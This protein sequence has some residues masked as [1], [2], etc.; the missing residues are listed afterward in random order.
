[1][2]TLGRIKARGDD[3]L[4]ADDFDSMPYLLAVVKVCLQ[5]SLS[6]DES[7]SPAFPRKL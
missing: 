4:A 5:A 6:V 3:D 7:R 2:D 1:M